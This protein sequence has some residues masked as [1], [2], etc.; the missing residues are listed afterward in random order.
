MIEIERFNNIDFFVL[1]FFYEG[2]HSPIV[3]AGAGDECHVYM[4]MYNKVASSGFDSEA[5][6]CPIATALASHKAC[7]RSRPLRPGPQRDPSHNRCAD[8]D[9][10]GHRLERFQRQARKIIL[11]S[12]PLHSSSGHDGYRVNPSPF[13]SQER[14]P[15]TSRPLH[16]MGFSRS[17]ATF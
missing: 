3:G 5:F 9:R 12:S 15:C 7:T 13:V 1:C 6:V 2:Q 16:V 4:Y 17:L 8:M 10:A 14:T 11:S